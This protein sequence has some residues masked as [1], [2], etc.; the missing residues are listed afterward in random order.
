MTLG[1]IGFAA[2]Q[3]GTDLEGVA[4]AFG[5]LNLQIADAQAGNAKT[6]E[7][8]RKLG[9]TV[10]DL[11]SLKSDEI[12]A[13]LAD[14]FATYDDDANKAA[15][16]NL[17]FGKTYQSVLPLLDEGGESLRK[18]IGYF[19][20]YSGVTEDLVK[21]SDQF[22]DSMT[23]LQLLNRAFANHL[24]AALL[25]SMQSL[26]EYLVEAKEKSTAFQD[27]AS[28]TIE[29]LKPYAKIVVGIGYAFAT[30]AD[31]VAGAAAA[32]SE[33]AAGRAGNAAK[34]LEDNAA[35]GIKR[36]E[37][38]RRLLDAIDGV[39]GA[40]PA[41]SDTPTAGRG[42]GKAPNFGDAGGGAAKSQVDEF[43][44]A[45]ERVSKMAAEADLELSGMFST[46]EITGAQKALA[47]LTSS[48]EWKKFTAPQQAELTNRLQAIDAIQRE[49]AEWKKKNDEQAKS[50]KLYEEQQQAAAKASEDF[51][52]ELGRYAE[53][54]DYLQRSIALVGQ[55]DV[56]RQKLAA[57]IEY[58]EKR[59]RALLTT[60][61][62]GLDILDEQ[63]RKR[64]A[65]IEKLSDTT[66]K[67]GEVQAYNAIF[68]NA[69]ADG[70]TQIVE[71]T[72]SVSDAFKDMAR[73]IE[74]EISRIAAQKLADAIF[75]VGTGKSGG[76]GDLL[77][78]LF[79][80]GSV[81][82][83]SILA[84]MFGG[85]V[86]GGDFGDWFIKIFGF[87]NGGNPPVGRLS[88]VGENGPELIYPRS[89]MTV[90]PLARTGGGDVHVH[91]TVN[92]ARGADTR[93]ARQAAGLVRDATI[94]AIKDR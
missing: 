24:A 62:A 32:I 43:A 58:E 73:T 41:A 7:T 68:A 48:D 94:K 93:S 35:R 83:G 19:E 23:K 55:D 18:N 80:G 38:F 74:Q 76:P 30:L 72:K 59:K 65:L 66:A 60:D 47:A 69:F 8:F 77:S 5:K 16:A 17:L 88:L 51:T 27:A 44:R 92:V 84:K 45:L 14:T 63:F 90:S 25:P 28:T 3:A 82:F 70:L 11:K 52:A 29:G 64:I 9:I 42:R 46:Q 13:K 67:F 4:K 26:V 89:A 33:L 39:K 22:N 50:I 15:A 75:G 40:R 12:F 37:E 20:R 53:E 6:V 79:S 2:Q 85:G 54:N 86:H 87:A 56:A 21:A 57:T 10:S 1:G 49:T 34:V 78:K 31:R 71:G 91:Q 36:W 81:D 61:T